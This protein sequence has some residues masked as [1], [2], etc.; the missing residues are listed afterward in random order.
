MNDFLIRHS[1]KGHGGYFFRLEPRGVSAIMDAGRAG[2]CCV[3]LRVLLLA[4]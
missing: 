3:L 1:L 4:V 2:I